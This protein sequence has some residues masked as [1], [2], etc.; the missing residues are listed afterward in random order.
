MFG[1][2]TPRPS[3]PRKDSL[4]VTL[5]PQ[6]PTSA[7][8]QPL[9][10]G[11]SMPRSTVQSP[12]LGSP[13]NT[14]APIR[15][16]G[17]SD[18]GNTAGAGNT[19][20]NGKAT[21]LSSDRRGKAQYDAGTSAYRIAYGMLPFRTWTTPD[22]VFS[23]IDTD[24][25]GQLSKGELVRFFERSPFDPSKI[26]AIFSQMDTDGSGQ[27]SREEWRRGFFE[28]GF[29]GSGVV[30][31][32]TEGFGM[33][34]S[35]VKPSSAVN[36]ALAELHLNR[37]PVRV[38]QPENRGI[39][40]PQLR[41][42]WDHVNKRCT[43]ENWMNV[44]GDLL[45]PDTVTMYDVI[46]YVV[47]PCTLKGGGVSY[48]EQCIGDGGIITPTWTVVHWWGDSFRDILLCIE[49][50]ARDR[51]VAEEGVAY[52][53][54]AFSLSQHRGKAAAADLTSIPSAI[55]VSIGTLFVCD[56]QGIGFR[57]LW[58]L[59]EMF[60]AATT[61][62]YGRAKLVDIY[63]PFTHISKRRLP[64][65]PVELHAVGLA[66]GFTLIDQ[67]PGPRGGGESANKMERESHFPLSLIDR[68]LPANADE[69]HTSM[70]QDRLALL[71]DLTSRG[72]ET[73]AFNSTVVARFA[74][75][76]LRRA[77]DSGN[78]RFLARSLEAVRSSPLTHIT[79]NLSGSRGF[80]PHTAKVL[81][82][83]LPATIQ[84]LSVQF[85]DVGED[86]ADTFLHELA[87]VIGGEGTS[88]S[89]DGHTPKL[90][91]IKLLSNNITADAGY[92]LGSV[93]SSPPSMVSIDWGAPA[94]FW[95]KTA[96]AIVTVRHVE[97]PISYVDIG[98]FVELDDGWAL[99]MK[100]MSLT[101]TDLILILSGISR[102]KP[103]TLTSLD[104]SNNN[105]DLSSIKLLDQF[106]ENG[107][108]PDLRWLALSDNK[109]LP[110]KAKKKLLETMKQYQGE[111]QNCDFVLEGMTNMYDTKYE[112]SPKA[113]ASPLRNKRASSA[114]K[115]KP[116][117]TSFP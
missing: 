5:V 9:A 81:A 88:G 24:N 52:W 51:G 2:L 107:Q 1:S 44:Q 6:R 83:S 93:L 49:Q 62:S 7:R 72:V 79:V 23:V 35:L 25:S 17:V 115:T 86:A 60:L 91:R 53:M 112:I 106:I 58:L 43:N 26:E 67:G 85:C 87:E 36:A 47:K 3:T 75:A 92:H 98:R 71:N 57:R 95:D 116:K 14:L 59:F 27:I 21:R 39:T 94:P 73:S 10:D 101:T 96:S 11:S 56:R 55:A 38:P 97:R 22:A 74:L 82:K 16:P 105:L 41:Q 114:K 4:R 19:P 18:G 32:S 80:N 8:L 20:R 37:P 89:Y 45:E 78:G 33:L 54:A 63:A 46:R 104:L 90:A 108:L 110:E 103:R 70:E 42:L 13:R 113:G 31:H 84:V 69:A 12:R 117:K 50:H 64:V 30:G 109:D 102:G 29:D 77:F 65:P 111:R 15:L 76:A 34:L 61:K 48:V 100:A 99:S 40:L 66:D 28:A 68:A